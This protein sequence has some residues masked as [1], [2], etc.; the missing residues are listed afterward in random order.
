M[1]NKFFKLI[2][3]FSD[4]A[5]ISIED[6]FFHSSNVLTRYTLQPGNRVIFDLEFNDRRQRYSAVNVQHLQH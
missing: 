6:I 5:N 3:T 2:Y 4:D 1:N